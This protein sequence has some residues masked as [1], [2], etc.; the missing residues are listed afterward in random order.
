MNR[1]SSSAKS[2]LHRSS[3]VES[4]IWRPKDYARCMQHESVS[5]KLNDYVTS[6]QRENE[7]KRTKGFVN[8][9]S[10][11]AKSKLH[12][13]SF[14]ES[15]IWRP[16]DCAGCKRRCCRNSASK[17]WR[18]KDYTILKQHES[19]SWKLNDYVTSNQH[20][21]ESKR[22][23]GF[24][25][26]SS[27]SAKSKLHRSSFVESRIWRPEDCAGC[28]RRCYRNSASKRWRPKDYTILKQHERVSWKLNDYVIL[29]QRESWRPTY[30]LRP[31]NTNARLENAIYKLRINERPKGSVN[32]H[33]RMRMSQK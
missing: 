22:T 11:N 32:S 18:P 9:S 7:S 24:V 31:K 6:N 12:R 3:V 2:K 29:N 27:S 20:E 23:K 4:R 13:S 5:W 28:K 21:N 15:R 10:S 8:R 26:R 33:N 1:S 19:V 17:R 14:V 30:C 16:K 25:N